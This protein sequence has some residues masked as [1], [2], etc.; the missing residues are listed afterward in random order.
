MTT[1]RR[2]RFQ[3][4]ATLDTHQLVTPDSARADE[5]GAL[6][7]RPSVYDLAALGLALDL[8]QLWLCADWCRARGLLDDEPSAREMM[9][10][11]HVPL[12]FLTPGRPGY[13]RHGAVDGAWIGVTHAA[14]GRSIDI[15]LTPLLDS[16]TP[17]PDAGDAVELQRAL[18]LY[19]NSVGAAFW[20]TAAR[21]GVSLMF[22]LA[23][24]GLAQQEYEPC[25]IAH[26]EPD[27]WR[28]IRP[29]TAREASRRYIHGYDKSAMYL[30]AC[31][32]VDLGTG[33]WM[34]DETGDRS[35]SG[36]APGY[37]RVVVDWPDGRLPSAGLLPSPCGGV[38]DHSGRPGVWM[39]A[40]TVRL[41]ARLGAAI[42]VQESWTQPGRIRALE[43]WYHR[44]RDA[45]ASLMTITGGDLV[46]A[47][48]ALAA[49][50]QTY[51]GGIGRLGSSF[52]RNAPGGEAS[53]LYRPE[54]RHHIIAQA[55]ANLYYN[56]LALEADDVSV[57]AVDTDAIYV[58][59]DDPHAWQPLGAAAWS[60]GYGRWLDEH[61]GSAP[62]AWRHLGTVET[63]DARA[64]GALDSTTPRALRDAVARR[65]HR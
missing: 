5:H 12:G 43:A 55:R 41:A 15:V 44:I 46:P 29:L 23:P 26:N 19:H 63:T 64:A 39:T 35:A 54:W 57:F 3:R 1:T 53:P 21:T 49:V 27:G 65:G 61:A 33:A 62:G 40:P 11:D 60:Q 13:A 31:S 36:T 50:K 17:W 28:W 34:H 51:T 45:R 47:R 6:P 8:D 48:L 30:A 32:S 9:A 24:R 37:Y 20:R 58:A 10:E 18:T 4:I 25:P 52:A 59:S 38:G 56:L 22:D 2:R 14:T 42:H 16:G 7:D